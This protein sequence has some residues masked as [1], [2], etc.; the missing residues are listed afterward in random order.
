MKVYVL[1][2][3]PKQLFPCE[4]LYNSS[5][6]LQVGQRRNTIHY[7]AKKHSKRSEMPHFVRKKEI[8]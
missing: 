1:L 7:Y 4:K 6:I 2:I 3:D 8:F 5:Y